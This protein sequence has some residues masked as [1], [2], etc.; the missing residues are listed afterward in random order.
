MV[1]LSPSLGIDLDSHGLQ[2]KSMIAAPAK[3]RLV[4]SPIYDGD[5]AIKGVVFDMD[6]TLTV[7]QNWMFGK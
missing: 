5:V 3:T 4:L 6:G 1:L 7:P 2:F